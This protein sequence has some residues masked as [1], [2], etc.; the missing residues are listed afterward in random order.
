MRHQLELVGNFLL[1][2]FQLVILIDDG[3]SVVR[4]EVH[5]EG[6]DVRGSL[7][8]LGDASCHDLVND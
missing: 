7:A 4:V 1:C 3:A 5:N 2:C 6:G 8:Y